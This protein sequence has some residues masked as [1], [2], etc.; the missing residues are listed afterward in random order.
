[1]LIPRFLILM[2]VSAC[3]KSSVG[4]A[5]AT[6]L[7]W[8]FYEADDFHPAEN[9]AKMTAGIPL[10]DHDRAPWLDAL[11]DLITSCLAAGRP[12]VLACS[13]LKERYR[14]VLL[15]GNTGV[16]VVY[17]KGDYD[18]IC[19]RIAART[20]H[21]MK[22]AMLESQFEDL[23]EPANTLIVDAGL[24]VDQIVDYVERYVSGVADPSN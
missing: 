8:D 16:E 24:P 7:R 11:H 3:G 15:A 19:S 5:L 23:E 4:R 20:G 18:L 2:G 1:M 10:G 13:A 6:R 12:G 22:P 17:L 21:Y 14:Q 9:I